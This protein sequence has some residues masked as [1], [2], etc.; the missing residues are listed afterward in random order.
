MNICHYDWF[1]KEVD[2]PIPRQ[3]EVGWDLQTTR[4]HK[5]EREGS[6]ES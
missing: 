4:E 1:N 3:G 2:W 6:W 5:K